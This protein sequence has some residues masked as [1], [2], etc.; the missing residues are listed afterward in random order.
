MF[1]IFKKPQ[2]MDMSGSE[3][4]N[5]YKNKSLNWLIN[6]IKSQYEVGGIIRIKIFNEK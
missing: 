5:V 1:S 6:F 3:K 4:I 2:I